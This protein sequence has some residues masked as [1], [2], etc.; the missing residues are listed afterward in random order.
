MNSARNAISVQGRGQRAVYGIN[1]HIPS[2]DGW[3]KKRQNT[4]TRQFYLV[5]KQNEALSFATT[6]MDLESMMLSEIR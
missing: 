1:L 3:V 2:N 4:D 5:I 6:W